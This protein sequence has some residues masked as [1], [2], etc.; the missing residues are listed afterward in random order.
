MRVGGS[1][2]QEPKRDCRKGDGIGRD[3]KEEMRKEQCE[4]TTEM[5]RVYRDESCTYGDIKN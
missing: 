3:V 1:H 4:G 5:E 2:H